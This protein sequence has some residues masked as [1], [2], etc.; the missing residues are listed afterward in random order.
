MK[1]SPL[2]S[3]KPLA[4]KAKTKPWL[5][6]DGTPK[7]GRT[8]TGAVSKKTLT[9][10]LDRLARK[11]CH[12]R[13]FCE[14]SFWQKFNPPKTTKGE[15]NG[16]LQWCH[17]EGRRHK[18]IRWSPMNCLCMCASCHAYFTDHSA[19]FGLMVEA[20]YPGR[21]QFLAELDKDTPIIDFEYWLEYYKSRAV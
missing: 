15:C 11:D 2:K 6:P 3:G 16:G 21:L 1:R 18:K 4:R 10:R 19:E 13:G 5:K 12:A 14:A 17:I 8:K 7:R 20:L 9:D